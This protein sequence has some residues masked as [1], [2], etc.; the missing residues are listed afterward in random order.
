M[1]ING[2]IG[3]EHAT[4]KGKSMREKVERG[5]SSDER[6]EKE[7]RLTVGEGEEESGLAHLGTGGIGRDEF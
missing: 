6:I 7:S 4:K 2:L 5:V 3:T 1:A